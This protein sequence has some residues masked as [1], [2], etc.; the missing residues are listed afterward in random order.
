V[1]RLAWGLDGIAVVLAALAVGILVTGRLRVGGLTL[2]RA[3]D[4]VVILALVVGARLALVPAAL[5]R[6]SGIEVN[7]HQRVDATPSMDLMIFTSPSPTSLRLT[8]SLTAG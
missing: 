2:E 3:E 7:R 4:L 8:V 5:P 1:R 6:V